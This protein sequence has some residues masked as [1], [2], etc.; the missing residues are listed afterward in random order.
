[1]TD[2][3]KV[4]VII[5]NYN[6]SEDTVD[7]L[8]SLS[9]VSQKN[10]RLSVIVVDNHSNDNF[11]S[12]IK[13]PAPAVIIE[14]KENL[15][16]TGGNNVGIKRAL[17]EN[18]DYIMLLN[19]DTY[20]DKNLIVNLL[21]SFQKDRTIGIVGPKIYFARGFEFHIEKYTD[22][23]KGRV[24]W[25]AGGLIDW[26]NMLFF[27]RGVDEV[28]HGQYEEGE[29]EFVSG[30]AMMIKAEL[31]KK[32]GM[33]N[34]DYFLYMEDVDLCQRIKNFGYKLWFEPS[35]IVWHKNATSSGKPG[36]KTHIY[37][38]ARNRLIFGFK[39]AKLRTKLA[40]IRESLKD[41]LGGSIKSKA[42]MD[43][44]FRQWGKGAI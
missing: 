10:Y 3:P 7:C 44:Y 18:A 1:M 35:A 15:G 32:I 25:Y 20:V 30:C 36:S 43:Y 37:Y 19:N 38:Q 11:L 29:T 28:D 8:K 24:I 14:N 41:L 2:K 9:E 22:N 31:I 16:F 6:G 12:L 42:V 40:L 39:Y 4:Y 17:E 21:K 13:S 23:Q 34:D 5:L 33:F 26:N 27:H